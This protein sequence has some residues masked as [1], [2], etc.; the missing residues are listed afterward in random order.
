MF[1][2]ITY[3]A[4]RR[5]T[6]TSSSS[7][8]SFT[9][10]TNSTAHTHLVD[11]F[12]TWDNA[13]LDCLYAPTCL[14]HD[15]RPARSW[16]PPS[17]TSSRHGECRTECLIIEQKNLNRGKPPWA[18]NPLSLATPHRWVPTQPLLKSK[19]ETSVSQAESHS[20][21]AEAHMSSPLRLSALYNAAAPQI[22]IRRAAPS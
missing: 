16:A 7:L 3:S 6:L 9:R 2:Q 17:P 1:E 13:L 20:E 19:P 22:P 15:I 21:K 18:Q 11:L 5:T 4:G 12:T 10:S 14:A 8:Q